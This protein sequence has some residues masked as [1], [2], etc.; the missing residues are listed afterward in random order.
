MASSY[1]CLIVVDSKQR[2]T[3]PLPSIKETRHPLGN[4]RLSTHPPS[5]SDLH[6][7]LF[8]KNTSNTSS[9]YRPYVFRTVTTFHSPVLDCIAGST[10]QK[11][12]RHSFYLIRLSLRLFDH[13]R[14]LCITAINTPIFNPE[15]DVLSLRKHSNQLTSEMTILDTSRPPSQQLVREENGQANPSLSLNLSSC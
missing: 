15:N 13:F 5:V 10:K 3:S 2:R 1:R 6:F 11:H 9:S 7:S 14:V 4:S 8:T 12:P